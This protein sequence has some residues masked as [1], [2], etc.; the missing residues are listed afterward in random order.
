MDG[1]SALIRSIRLHR[2]REKLCK[3]LQTGRSFYRNADDQL[4]CD[5]KA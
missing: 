2:A 5:R 3:S 1:F 4:A